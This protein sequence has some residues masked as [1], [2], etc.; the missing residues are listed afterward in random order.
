M[1]VWM[2]LLY[3]AWMSDIFSY[4]V[5]YVSLSYAPCTYTQ[6]ICVI[7]KDIKSH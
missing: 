1:I 5:A 7:R 6:Q 2:L 4:S 3:V